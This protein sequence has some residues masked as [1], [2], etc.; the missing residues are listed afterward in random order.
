MNARIPTYLAVA[1][2]AGSVLAAEPI[3]SGPKV[4]DDVPGS[5][6]PLNITGADAGQK[7]CLV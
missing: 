6:N 5:F 1:L 4:G 7:R 3:K 2:L